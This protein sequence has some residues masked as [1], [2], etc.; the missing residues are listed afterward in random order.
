MAHLRRADAAL[1]GLAVLLAVAATAAWI[2]RPSSATTFRSQIANSD[3]EAGSGVGWSEYAEEEWPII[4]DDAGLPA[5]IGPH[6]GTRAARLGGDDGEQTYLEQQVTLRAA[7]PVLAYWHWIDSED[8]CGSDWARV[9]V[10][11]SP[12]ASYPLCSYANTPGW[13]KETVDLSAFIGRTVQLRLQVETDTSRPSYLYIDDVALEASGPA[14][15]PNTSTSTATATNTPTNTP[16]STATTTSTPTSTP[17]NTA[18]VTNTP[19]STPTNT[20][21]ATNTPTHTPTPT[22]SA[23]GA[24]HIYLPLILRKSASGRE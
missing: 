1:Y 21:T 3:F 15:Y 5:G 19:T 12:V 11:G 13:V 17:T 2:W 7:R 6:G 18:T 24:P 16:T 23:T 20:T 9:L 22:P 10:N 8:S 14:A 4:V